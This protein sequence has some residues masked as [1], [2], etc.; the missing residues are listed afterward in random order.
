MNIRMKS[1]PKIV[2]KGFL[3]F[4]I[5]LLLPIVAISIWAIWEHLR[6]PL[7]ALDHGNPEISVVRDSI[8]TVEA[9]SGIRIYHDIVLFAGDLDSI[10]FTLSLPAGKT[11]LR[12][13]V[14]MVIGGLE[15][16]RTSLRYVGHHGDNVLIA[17]EYP[18]GP[19]YWYEGTP[20][21]EIPAIRSA[22]RSVPAQLEAVVRW[23]RMQPWADTGRISTFSYSFGAMFVPA[24][25]RLAASRGSTMGPA[26]LMYGGVDIEA[27]LL[28]NLQ[29]ESDIVRGIFAWL[30][31]TAI[32]PVEP[33][34]HLPHL[35][36]ELLIINGTRDR[37]IPEECWRS[38][39]EL[40]P[41]PKT[42]VNLETGHMH[43]GA[44]EL[45]DRLVETGRQ[46]LLER[47]AIEN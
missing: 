44:T 7:A 2:R 10:R 34:L 39:Q 31:A 13:P 45:I 16:G 37:L 40:A 46:W 21:T 9:K 1:G 38:L 35:H 25:Y 6:D 29:I 19:E 11:G 47:E 12:F 42:I 22:V 28:H 4:L 32:R 24:F 17:Y 14:I 5:V 8:Y 26:T 43:P 18:Y 20:L 41:E 15:I 30:A 3:L 27:L 33:A 36:S 23:A